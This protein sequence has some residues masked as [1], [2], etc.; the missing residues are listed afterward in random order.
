VEKTVEHKNNTASEPKASKEK[1]AAAK[2][3]SNQ[4]ISEE[5]KPVAPA[6]KVRLTIRAKKSGWLQVKVDGNLVFQATLEQG[7]T[8][9]WV[10]EKM[11]ELSGKNIYNLDFEVNGKVVGGLG[12]DDRSARRVVITDSGLSVKSSL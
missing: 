1:T 9:S 3:T 5:D 4:S 7:A 6:K 10:A 11:I 12:R 8:E 2:E